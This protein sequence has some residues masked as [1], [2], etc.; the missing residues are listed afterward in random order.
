MGRF[1]MKRVSRSRDLVT[2]ALF[3]RDLILNLLLTCYIYRIPG[4]AVIC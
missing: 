2:L 1:W 3:H 4:T